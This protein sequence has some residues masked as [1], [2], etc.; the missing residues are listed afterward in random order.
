MVLL[1]HALLIGS[2]NILFLLVNV[3]VWNQHIAPMT[4]HWLA[5]LEDLC[6]MFAFCVGD[7]SSNFLYSSL[8][9]T[10]NENLLQFKIENS[11]TCST[12]RRETPLFYSY[13]V[14]K[15]IDM[16]VLPP[17]V[18]MSKILLQLNCELWLCRHS[19]CC[20]PTP[21]LSMKH[22]SR[23][24][25]TALLLWK[26]LWVDGAILGWHCNEEEGEWQ[27]HSLLRRAKKINES[28]HL[29]QGRLALF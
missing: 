23:Q 14:V 18:A 29:L 11:P 19:S 16:S 3:S 12:T 28:L 8:R 2:A 9:S 21:L 10:Q 22:S 20:P 25:A 15:W 17:K 1:W 6:I 5:M 24:C 4:A 26:S 7:S 27:D 13:S